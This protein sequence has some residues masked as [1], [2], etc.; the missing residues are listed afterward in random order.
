MLLKLHLGQSWE[1]GGGTTFFGNGGQGG[2]CS[3]AFTTYV[4]GDVKLMAANF[5]KKE[6]KKSVHRRSQ[7][8]KKRTRRKKARVGESTQARY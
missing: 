5:E 6:A 2:Q 4:F 1:G 3:L 8:S 7:E